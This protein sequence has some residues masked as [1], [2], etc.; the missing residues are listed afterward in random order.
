MSFGRKPKQVED[1]A[2]VEAPEPTPE[3][4]AEQPAEAPPREFRHDSYPP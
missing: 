1:E 2:P 3:V 4:P